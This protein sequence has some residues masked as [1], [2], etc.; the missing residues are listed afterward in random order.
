MASPLATVAVHHPPNL[1]QRDVFAAGNCHHVPKYFRLVRES[2]REVCVHGLAGDVGQVA[3][4]PLAGGNGIGE[5]FGEGRDAEAEV[6]HG[7]VVILAAVVG[8]E[9]VRGA[10]RGRRGQVP[11]ECGG[12][13][14]LA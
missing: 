1:S 6:L 5:A 9:E 4:L 3:P 14:P 12:V 11:L 8:G 7:L 10:E 13:H 2:L